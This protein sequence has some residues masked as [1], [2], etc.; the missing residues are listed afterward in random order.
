MLGYFAALAL[1][2]PALAQSASNGSASNGSASAVDIEGLQANFQ[3]A[4]S[5]F[6]SLSLRLT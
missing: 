1:A 4:P 6:F 5:L 3:R 2:L